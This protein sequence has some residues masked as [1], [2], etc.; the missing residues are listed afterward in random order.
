MSITLNFTLHPTNSYNY[1]VSIY[2]KIILKKEYV[3]TSELLPQIEI[4]KGESVPNSPTCK[5]LLF[6]PPPLPSSPHPF[7]PFPFPPLPSLSLPFP[8]LPSSLLFSVLRTEFRDTMSYIPGHFLFLF[9]K[10]SLTELLGCLSWA[11]AY[12]PPSCLSL[13]DCC[14]PTPS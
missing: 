7:P 14:T 11:W 10:H 1:K 5:A 9:L 13:P 3:S 12:D 8:P 4:A 2:N 6:L